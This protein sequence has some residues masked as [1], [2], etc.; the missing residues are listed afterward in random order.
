MRDAVN[1]P[2]FTVDPALAFCADAAATL[3]AA[4]AADDADPLDPARLRLVSGGL[5]VREGVQRASE[6]NQSRHN[7]SSTFGMPSVRRAATRP[8]GRGLDCGWQQGLPLA[9]SIG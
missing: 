3:S 5:S 2:F 6:R 1:A 7:L 9:Y 4:A 8:A